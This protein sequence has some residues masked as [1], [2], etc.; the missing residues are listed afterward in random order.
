VLFITVGL[1]LLVHPFSPRPA[2]PRVTIYPPRPVCKISHHLLRRSNGKGKRKVLIAV[3]YRR[4]V[5]D[6]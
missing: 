6:I 2:V 3:K 4:N 1:L 5:A